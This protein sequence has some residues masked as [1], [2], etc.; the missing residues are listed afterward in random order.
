MNTISM[1][2]PV[3]KK[4]SKLDALT[5]LRL[6]AALVVVVH[7]AKGYL[8]PESF[9][10]PASEAVSF[11]FVLSGFILTYIYHERTYSLRDYYLARIA[12]ILPASLLSIAVFI[13]LINPF[14][15]DPSSPLRPN[16]AI[17]A[18]NLFLAQSLIPIPAYY[19]ALNA[20]LWSVSV[21]A[22]FYLF[23]PA[24]ERRLNSVLGQALLLAIP[25]FIGLLLVVICSLS[26][27][28]EYSA[29][30]F[31]R[32]TW[33]GL[34]Y[35]NPLSRLKEFTIGMLAGLAYKRRSHRLLQGNSKMVLSTMF[36][37]LAIVTLAW[38]LPTLY[39]FSLAMASKAGIAPVALGTYLH[40]ILTAILFA[41]IILLFAIQGGLVS[42]MLRSKAMV[43]GGEISFSIYLFHQIIILW[44]H[45]NPWLLG[46][47]PNQY[48]F[49]LFL[50][51]IVAVSYGAWRWFECPMRALIR[52]AFDRP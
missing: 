34:I 44:Q 2:N 37:V 35:V 42:R 43:I 31:N 33:H 8:I 47:C 23:F 14:A 49:P 38:G 39:S 51:F 36:E 18:S 27:Y 20:V 25:L 17:T 46:W 5:S 19:F 30:A 48:K 22:F 52:R 7:H 13:L 24:L 1:L 10:V 6:V 15:F 41:A 28:P 3:T 9:F 4:Y 12:R 40:Q 11:F 16:L 26:N 21:E 29:S 50:V 45:K 32:I